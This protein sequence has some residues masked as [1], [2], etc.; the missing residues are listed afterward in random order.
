[1]KLGL[2]ASMFYQI[3]GRGE[4]GFILQ[5]LEKNS[6]ARL[7]IIREWAKNNRTF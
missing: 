3:V 5:V 2:S 7:I 6:Q 4:R 1:M